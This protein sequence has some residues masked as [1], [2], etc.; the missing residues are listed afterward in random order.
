MAAPGAVFIYLGTYPSEAAARGDY[1]VVKDF[2]AGDAVGS[3][4]ATVITR[5]SAGK[6]HVDEDEM[7][8]RHGAWAGAAVGAV[9]GVWFPPDLIGSATVGAAVGRV[10]GQLWRG[11]SGADAKKFDEVIDSGQ[12]ALVIVGESTLEQ[13]LREV[14]TAERHVHRKLDVS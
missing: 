6:V 5:D 11:M 8:T 10:G 3:Y 2:H 13:A 4:D 1:D 7:A 9:A 14:L 12:A